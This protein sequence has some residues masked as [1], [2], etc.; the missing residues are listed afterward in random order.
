M[1]RQRKARRKQAGAWK[2]TG[3]DRA[4]TDVQSGAAAGKWLPAANRAGNSFNAVLIIDQIGT[5]GDGTRP[6]RGRFC[7]GVGRVPSPGGGDRA[8]RT[9]AFNGAFLDTFGGRMIPPSPMQKNKI[10]GALLGLCLLLGLAGS[11]CSPS[12]PR[13]LKEGRDYLA[14]GNTPAAIECFQK[15]VRM[16]PTNA[17]A[18]AHLGLALQKA[19][20][21]TNAIACCQQA[22]LR[23]RDLTEVHYNL[24]CL[25]LDAGDAESAKSEFTAF[26]FHQP[27]VIDARRISGRA[28]PKAR[29]ARN[30]VSPR[31]CGWMSIAARHGTA[32]AWPGLNGTAPARPPTTLPA[33]SASN[34]VTLPPS[35]IS[36]S[37]IINTSATNPPRCKPTRI[38]SP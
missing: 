23:D 33:P 2:L 18:Y 35:S 34:P 25:W 27:K 20:R 4:G 32:W 3:P 12:G 10:P 1:A 6:S 19:G 21:T 16:M 15:A 28:I 30:S 26:T 24:G 22:L 5:P 36:L 8:K 17:L 38:T 31:R 37:S 11:G 7:G 13:V 9:A 14:R 29:K